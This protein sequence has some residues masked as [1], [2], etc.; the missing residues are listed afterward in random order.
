MAVEE[1]FGLPEPLGVLGGALLLLL[2]LVIS[3][4]MIASFPS[5]STSRASYVRSVTHF[6][7]RRSHTVA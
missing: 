1:E 6:S 4:L 3:M 5:S 2:A 7:A